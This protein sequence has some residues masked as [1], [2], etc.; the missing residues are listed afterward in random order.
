MREEPTVTVGTVCA[1]PTLDNVDMFIDGTRRMRLEIIKGNFKLFHPA[2]GRCHKRRTSRSFRSA[3]KA[4][5]EGGGATERQRQRVFAVTVPVTRA[6]NSNPVRSRWTRKA[7]CESATISESSNYNSKRCLFY[8]AMILHL[9][10][11][12]RTTKWVLHTPLFIIIGKQG[13][14]YQKG[15]RA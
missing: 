14:S 3:I 9:Y 6:Q 10:S 7:S 12:Y 15:V 1:R 8:V 4:G 13:Q 11:T 5:M 2:D